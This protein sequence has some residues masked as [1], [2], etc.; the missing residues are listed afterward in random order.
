MVLTNNMGFKADTRGRNLGR[1]LLLSRGQ[2]Q[3]LPLSSCEHGSLRF[4]SNTEL[5]ACC[6][7]DLWPQ[8]RSH[9]LKH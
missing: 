6:L 2:E 3:L 9:M 1:C 8:L 7:G 5:V 4:T